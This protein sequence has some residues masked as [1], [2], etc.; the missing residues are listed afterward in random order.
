MVL[1]GPTA[2]ATL[3][4]QSISSTAMVWSTG[5]R[6][7]TVGTQTSAPLLLGTNNIERLRIDTTGNVGIGTIT[8]TATLQVS[9]TFTVSNSAQVTTPSIYVNS[10][11]NV[12][13]GTSSPLS[14]LSV[15]VNGVDATSVTVARLI[16][17][18]S[19][20]GTRAVLGFGYL[21]QDNATAAIGGGYD[22]TGLALSFYTTAAAGS[23]NLVER[24]TLDHS[25]NLGIGTTS[26]IAKLDITGTASAS[27]AIQVSGSSL[28][29]APSINGA[30]R[31][32]SVS[33]SIQ[34]CQ[35]T[36]WASLVSSTSGGDVTG[37][38]SA[39]QVAYWSGGSTLTGSNT[40]FFNT[41]TGYLGLGITNPAVELAVTKVDTTPARIHVQNSTTGYTASDGFQVAT[42]SGNAYLWNWE[43][44]ATLFGTSN[45]EQMRITAAGKVGIGTASPAARLDVS[46][47]LGASTYVGAAGNFT[48]DPGMYG[49]PM[50]SILGSS[51]AYASD[52][53]QLNTNTAS[54]TGY[55]FLRA[56][57]DVDG[58]PANAVWIRGD[59]AGY[60]AG[61]VGVGTTAPTAKLHV[62]SSSAVGVG[63][64]TSTIFA[65]N[66]GYCDVQSSDIRAAITG[67]SAYNN[68][69]LDAGILGYVPT[70][71]HGVFAS[72]AIFDRPDSNHRIYVLGSHIG[73]GSNSPYIHMVSASGAVTSTAFIV[74]EPGDV[75]IGTGSPAS[76]L[77]VSSTGQTEIT[78]NGA[79][80]GYN[81]GAL[82]IKG[83]NDTAADLAS[84]LMAMPFWPDR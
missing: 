57:Q 35:G 24:M 54:G 17:P 46:A 50:F 23:G 45:T 3:F 34:V 81:Q 1:Y 64:G 37:G 21:D 75:G 51:Q 71:G 66:S 65:N 63:L 79:G 39:G 62:V 8:P 28:T 67:M 7:L 43:N 84:M 42:S 11:G 6:L 72:A 32:S 15:R 10:S 41:G 9:G 22:G 4:G 56:I 18:G 33:G 82:V 30:I 70:G 31:Y 27:D 49:Y 48:S 19:N 5:S 25:G 12:G 52:I 40:L 60:F 55:Y 80:V 61:R 20:T 29:C 2:S 14:K 26:P 47:S 59:G 13:V 68:G 83:Y 69:L 16:Q 73:Y 38:G 53:L 58:T 36:T 78:I 76:K 74:T 77:E 44:A